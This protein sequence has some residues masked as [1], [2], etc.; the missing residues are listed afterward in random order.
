MCK[1]T[2]CSC[3][4]QRGR[5]ED[6]VVDSDYRGQKLGN[7]LIELLKKLARYLNCYKLTLDCNDEMIVFYE[8]F[9]F[10]AEPGRANLLT[11]RLEE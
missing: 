9:G 4:H 3:F 7:V 10:I 1:F 2:I 8:K 11:I 5:I 6:V